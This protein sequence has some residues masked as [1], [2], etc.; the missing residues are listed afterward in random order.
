MNAWVLVTLLASLAAA[1]APAGPTATV[2]VVRRASLAKAAASDVASQV[3]SALQSSG[4]PVE[5]S[6]ATAAQK[7]KQLGVESEACEGVKE[8][9]L[10]LGSKLGVQMVVAIE[11]GALGRS[12]A[13][14]LDVLTVPEGRQM[15]QHDLVADQ[16]AVKKLTGLA[17]FGA[18]VHTAL[19][20]ASSPPPPDSGKVEPTPP[21]PPPTPAPEVTVH[22]TKAQPDAATPVPPEAVAKPAP[23]PAKSHTLGYVFTSTAVAAAVTSGA[24][25]L[26]GFLQM[27][28]KKQCSVGATCYGASQAVEQDRANKANT[29]FTASLGVLGGAVLLGVTA[30]IVW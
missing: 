9:V 20:A 3:A 22:Q 25:A 28:D 19:A 23:P 2:L 5:L 24:L 10:A 21:P 27:P 29:E 30:V 4:V 1:P 18:R 12:V 6:P 14:H 17:E 26:A 15:A 11:L 16:D 7:L 8:C 13:I